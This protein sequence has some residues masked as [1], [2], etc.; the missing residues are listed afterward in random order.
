[1]LSLVEPLYFAF[2]VVLR[3]LAYQ[4]M[5]HVCILVPVVRDVLAPV[6]AAFNKLTLTHF[7]LKRVDAI[8]PS[9]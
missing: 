7:Q 4:C 9:M 6:L 5:M 2:Y 1:M 8:L 3:R